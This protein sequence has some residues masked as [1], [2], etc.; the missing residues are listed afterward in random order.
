[1]PEPNHEPD[2]TESE[3]KAFQKRKDL[4]ITMNALLLMAIFLTGVISF[5]VIPLVFCSI[6]FVALN[7]EAAISAKRN[8]H[9]QPI[10]HRAKTVLINLAVLIGLLVCLHKYPLSAVLLTGA[11][12]FPVVNIVL[13]LQAKKAN[14]GLNQE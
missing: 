6:G 3:R 11:V 12:F 1:M 13:F 2:S 9:M 5:E 14:K 7:I 4:F 8:K 10:S